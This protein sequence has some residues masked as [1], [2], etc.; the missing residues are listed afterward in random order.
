MKRK[1]GGDNGQK[2]GPS[3]RQL[4]VGEAIKKTLSEMFVRG[5]VFRGELAGTSV[6]VSE[7]RVTPDLK[8][9]MAFVM[10]LG[11]LNS[12]KVLKYLKDN[13]NEIRYLVTQRIE[14]KFSPKID[15]K[16]DNTYEYAAK[17]DSLLHGAKIDYLNDEEE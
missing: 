14:M 3:Q 1:F 6:T 13:T 17:I 2:A 15:F 4:R 10:P 5:F 7:V 11:G 12:E 9:A 8:N 16:L